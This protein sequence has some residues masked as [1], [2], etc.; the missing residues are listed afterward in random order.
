MIHTYGIHRGILIDVGVA[1]STKLNGMLS[2]PWF[3]A[4]GENVSN[5]FSWQF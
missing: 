5:L 2:P 3:M 4:G 1:E